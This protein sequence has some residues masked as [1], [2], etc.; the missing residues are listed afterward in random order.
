MSSPYIG[1]IRMFAGT[2]APVDWALCDGSLLSIAENDAL[3]AL[4]GTTY[5]GDGISTF[6]LPD[7]RG[8]SPLH[9]GQGPGLSYRVLGETMGQE[10]V[11]L[12]PNQMPQHSH[13]LQ[14]TSK[15]ARSGQSAADAMVATTTTPV[16]G[17]GDPV[18]PM[19]PTALAVTGLTQAHENMPPFLALNFIISLYGIFPSPS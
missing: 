15:P 10:Q 7:L 17:A 18:T 9:Q 16:Y 8:R 6:A 13:T 11:T 2:F 5:G 14:G 12:Q 3:F 4:I 1:E 19:A